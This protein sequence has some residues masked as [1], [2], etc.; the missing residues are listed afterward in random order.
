MYFWRD[1]RHTQSFLRWFTVCWHH[2]SMML[3]TATRIILF[4]RHERITCAVLENNDSQKMFAS[5]QLCPVLCTLLFYRIF[6]LQEFKSYLLCTCSYCK[7]ADPN[8]W[9]QYQDSTS[10]DCDVW[11]TSI[12]SELVIECKDWAKWL[13]GSTDCQGRCRFSSSSAPSRGRWNYTAVCMHGNREHADQ[14]RC[15]AP[16]LRGTSNL[17]GAHEGADAI[18]S[19]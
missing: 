3:L 13:Y 14:E 18:L 1:I 12:L 6:C 16:V 5:E 11:R 17:S 19:H 7:A 10:S 4:L 15:L 8:A 9:W 2:G